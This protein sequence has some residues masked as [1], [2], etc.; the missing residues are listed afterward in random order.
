MRHLSLATLLAVLWLGLSGHFE[1]L[2][3]ALGAASVSLVVWLARRMRVVDEEGLPLDSLHRAIPYSFWLLGQIVKANLAMLPVIFTRRPA[4]KPRV[5]T[6]SAGE[7]DTLG[8]VTYAN[9]ITMTPG[10]VALEVSDNEIAVHALTEQAA[11]GL[12]TGEMQRRA[13]RVA[14][15]R[16]KK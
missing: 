14:R 15:P 8:Q 6:I 5:L 9:S 13:E 3:L 11:A 16:T 1:G 2:V 7:A 10:T 4:I 12:A